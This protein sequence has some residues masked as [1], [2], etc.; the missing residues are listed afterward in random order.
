MSTKLETPGPVLQSGVTGDQVTAGG[1][2]RLLARYGRG[3]CAHLSDVD[4][5]RETRAFSVSQHVS[6]DTETDGGTTK[7]DVRIPTQLLERIDELYEERGYTSRSEAIRDALRDWVD[8]P[9]RLSEEALEDL[10]AEDRE[11]ILKKLSG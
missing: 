8:P 9:I 3:S 4:L 10:K 2:A 1:T 5:D 6:T 7:I 11:R